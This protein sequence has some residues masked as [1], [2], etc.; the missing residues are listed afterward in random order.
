MASQEILRSLLLE[1]TF[2]SG[3]ANPHAVML[4]TVVLERWSPWQ[5][6]KE[7]QSVTRSFNKQEVLQ[8]LDGVAG[9]VE[10]TMAR[11]KTKQLNKTRL[12]LDCS[13]FFYLS[14]INSRQPSK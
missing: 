5:M 12:C 1:Q 6:T 11:T 2:T 10:P 8:P 7:R 14:G 4:K 3:G 13:C 9:Y